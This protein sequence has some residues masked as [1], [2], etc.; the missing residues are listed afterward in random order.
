MSED[1]VA[2]AKGHD[3][4]ECLRRVFIELGI[5]SVIVYGLFG[6]MFYVVGAFGQDPIKAGLNFIGFGIVILVYEYFVF[7]L[8]QKKV[9]KNSLIK[10]EAV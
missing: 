2:V 5:I 7:R 1:T 10:K 8:L 9:D 6:G 3:E 4:Q